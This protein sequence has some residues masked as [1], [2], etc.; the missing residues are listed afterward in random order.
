[1][2]HEVFSRWANA[3]IYLCGPTVLGYVAA[4]GSQDFARDVFPAMLRDGRRLLASPSRALVIDFGSPDRR[5]FAEQAIRAGS[6][7]RAVPESC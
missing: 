3:G 5:E 2:H 4:K 1:L 6:L 7:G